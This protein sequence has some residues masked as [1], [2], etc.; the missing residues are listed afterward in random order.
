MKNQEPLRQP[1]ELELLIL[2]VL[3][4]AEDQQTVPLAVRS[5]RQELDLRGRSL[6]HTSVITTLNIMVE[7][8]FLKR[9]KRKNAFYFSPLI[10]RDAVHDR[11]LDDL[12]SRVFDG[13]AKQLMLKLLD[14]SDVEPAELAEIQKLIRKKS[15]ESAE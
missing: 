6:A 13:S 11:V 15:R 14:H 3:W 7:K 4:D 2:Q 5:I 1:S 8:R 12:I 9:T 10:D